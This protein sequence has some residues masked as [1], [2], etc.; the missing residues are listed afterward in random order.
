MDVRLKAWVCQDE[1]TCQVR[2]VRWQGDLS[3][4]SAGEPALWFLDAFEPV[5]PADLLVPGK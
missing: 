2:S 3:V 4:T 5:G 1:G